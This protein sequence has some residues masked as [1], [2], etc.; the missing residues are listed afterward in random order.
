MEHR[1]TVLESGLMELRR[2]HRKL[3]RQVGEL[4]KA[5]QIAEGVAE[6]LGRMNTE[7]R[8]G[9]FSKR[10]LLIATAALCVTTLNGVVAALVAAHTLGAF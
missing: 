9:R 6:Q 1:I 8:T 7:A 3:E 4:V 2:Q 10:E 5:D